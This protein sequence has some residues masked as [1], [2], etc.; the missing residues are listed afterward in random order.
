MYAPNTENFIFGTF[1]GQ[2]HIRDTDTTVPPNQYQPFILCQGS[3]NQNKN[4]FSQKPYCQPTLTITRP[5]I[6]LQSI[7]C[8]IINKCFYCL[9][10]QQNISIIT[11]TVL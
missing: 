11:S 10:E 4:F 9:H 3:V 1:L 2:M 6:R 7:C 8:G 5:I